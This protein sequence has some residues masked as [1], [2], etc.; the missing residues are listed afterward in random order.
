MGSYL[1]KKSFRF[2][3]KTALLWLFLSPGLE[4]ISSDHFDSLK[5]KAANAPDSQ[6]VD[7]L[8]NIAWAYM[9]K[10][11]DSARLYAKRQLNQ[12]QTSNNKKGIAN[13]YNTLGA[14]HYQKGYYKKALEYYHQSNDIKQAINDES[15]LAAG[16][17]NIGLIHVNQGNYKKSIDYFIKSLEIKKSIKDTAGLAPSYNNIAMVYQ[18]QGNLKKA[19]NNYKKALNI[20][21]QTNNKTGL[22]SDY[23]NIGIIHYEQNNYNQALDYYMRSLTIKDS[24]GLTAKKSETYSNIGVAFMGKNNF[25]KAHQYFRESLVHDSLNGNRKGV[26]NSYFNLGKNNYHQKKYNQATTYL[27]K[28]Q[29]LARKIGTKPKLIKIYKFLSKTAEAQGHYSKALDYHKSYVM[30]QDSLHEQEKEKALLQAQTKYEVDQKEQEIELLNK[31]KALQEV[32]LQ[33]QQILLIASGIISVL[34]IGLALILYRSNQRQRNINQQLVEK[35]EQIEQQQRDIQEQNEQLTSKNEELKAINNDKNRFISILSHDLRNPLS[36]ITS[37]ADLLLMDDQLL[38][39]EQK[40]YIQYIKGSADHSSNMIRKLL[41]I[42]AIESRKVEPKME[43]INAKE[44]LDATLNQLREQ[45]NAKDIQIHQNLDQESYPI[46]ADPYYLRQIFDNLIGNALKYSNKASNIWVRLYQQDQSLRFEVED[47]GPGISEE[48]QQKLFQKFQKLSTK[49]T[50]NE[51]ATGLGLSIVKF[52]AE[53]MNG[54]VW[55]ESEL[56]NGTTFILELPLEKGD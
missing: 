47:E 13:A 34:I 40:Q 5:Q 49:P 50:G 2:I 29:E 56:N 36:Q 24:L 4:A 18:A 6:K 53:A 44:T 15:G 10:T 33:R 48:D 27:K 16:Y 21:K 54:Q 26:M 55:C 1:S 17:N 25:K 43:S 3:I 14:I 22:A 23:N 28:A 32:K 7:V 45:A 37:L 20:D 42:N 30:H 31:N 8:G 19:L 11:W 12:A 39:D 38:N 46:E 51:P 41:D 52:Y 35:N 9:G